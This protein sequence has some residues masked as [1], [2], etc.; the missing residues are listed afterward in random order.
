M[1]LIIGTYFYNT[2]SNSEDDDGFVDIDEILS[3]IG[4]DN[5]SASVELN[6]G[7][8]AEKFESGIGDGSP[9]DSPCPLE[10][11]T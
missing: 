2:S 9:A 4:R 5:I 3:N 10:R 6:S 8:M 1:P 7:G 11:S